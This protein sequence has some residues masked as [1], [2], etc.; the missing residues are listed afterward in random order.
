MN[1]GDKDKILNLSTDDESDLIHQPKAQPH[2]S[3]QPSQSDPPSDHEEAKTKKT[4]SKSSTRQSKASSPYENQNSRASRSKSNKKR[5]SSLARSTKPSKSPAPK[6]I[7]PSKAPALKSTK[8]S[9]SPVRLLSP[10]KQPLQLQREKVNLN[11]REMPQK[12]PYPVAQ[13]KVKIMIMTTPMGKNILCLKKVY[14]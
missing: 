13:L 11:R 14:S 10:A 2:P 6:K 9:K 7:I 1:K 5:K 8:S 12:V 4:V 3:N